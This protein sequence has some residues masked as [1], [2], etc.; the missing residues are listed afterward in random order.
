MLPVTFY[1]FKIFYFNDKEF[2]FLEILSYIFRI[3]LND[4]KSLIIFTNLISFECTWM[5]ATLMYH[6]ESDSDF[7][8]CIKYNLLSLSNN[9]NW[10]AFLTRIL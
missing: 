8:Y 5:N 2:L 7:L 6:L 3:L 10:S 4:V 1:T 9:K